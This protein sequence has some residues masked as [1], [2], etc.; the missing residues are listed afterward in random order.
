MRQTLGDRLRMVYT[1]DKGQDLFTSHAWRRL[2]EIRAPLLGGIRR[3]MTWRDFL[4]LTPSYVFI[5]DLMRRL[6]HRMIACS[7]L[8]RGQAPEKDNTCLDLAEGREGVVL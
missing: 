5:R 2:F 6:C 1:G 7:I 3:W 8:G 4:G